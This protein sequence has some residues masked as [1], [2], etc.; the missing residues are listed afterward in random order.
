MGKR[1][2]RRRRNR[3][4]AIVCVIF[5]ILAAIAL[6]LGVAF[7]TNRENFTPTEKEVKTSAGALAEIN[8][9]LEE[10]EM[11]V[12][13]EEHTLKVTTKSPEKLNLTDRDKYLLAKLAM[14]EAEG[15]SIELKAL[16]MNVVL[17]RV[18]S[19]GFPNTIEEVIFQHTTKGGKVVY[20]FSPVSSGGRWWTTEPNE[21]CF[22]AV[23]MV[24]NGYNESQKALYFESCSGESWHS[25]NLELLF[26]KESHRFYK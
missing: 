26:E 6:P 17:T 3:V 22:K 10:S 2:G 5:S 15:E 23:E 19:K 1:L 20:Q 21:D 25:R 18:E 9:P 11:N 4:I 13:I 16:V 24:I 7:D 8:K 12:V 14:A